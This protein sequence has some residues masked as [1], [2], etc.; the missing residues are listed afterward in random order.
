[1]YNLKKTK[2]N[3]KRNH[4][5]VPFE[6]KF[7]LFKFFKLGAKKL[8]LFKILYSRNYSQAT[9]Q[10]L[11]KTPREFFLPYDK[12]D[13]AYENRPIKIGFGQ[14]ISQPSLVCEMIDKLQVMPHHNVLEIGTGIGYN[15]CLISN[16]ANHITTVEIVSELVQ[17]AKTRIRFCQKQGIIRNNISLIHGDGNQGFKSKSPYDRIIVT[18][19]SYKIP[20]DLIE[21]LKE[22]GI[23]IIPVKERETNLEFLNIVTKIDGRIN[24]RKDTS[25]RFVPFIRKNNMISKKII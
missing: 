21:Q 16:L 20:P 12:V 18:C 14:T 25:V 13:L 17:R 19:G 24:I 15:A 11:E 10:S 8:E 7:L 2:K 4:L 3:T 23:M 22:G 1:M 6:K 9:I 5:E